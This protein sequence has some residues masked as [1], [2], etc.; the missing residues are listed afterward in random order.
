VFNELME[1]TLATP[2]DEITLSALL[3]KQSTIT[4]AFPQFYDRVKAISRKGGVRLK[5][6][7]PDGV[8]RFQAHSGTK[9]NTW[10]DVFI[11][12][13]GVE[14]VIDKAAT[15][16]DFW[17]KGKQGLNANALAND[18]IYT[19]DIQTFCECPADLYWAH[20][21]TRSRPQTN[22]KYT[23]QIDQA[24]TLRNVHQ[25]G[26]FCKHTQAVVDVLPMYHSSV[27][28]YLKKDFA[29][30]IK[31][32]EDANGPTI[33]G[34]DKP[35]DDKKLIIPGKEDKPKPKKLIVPTQLDK[36]KDEP[37][38]KPEEEPKDKPEEEPDDKEEEETPEPEP[39]KD[40]DEEDEEEE[41]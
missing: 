10:Y 4:Q 22:A 34:E 11:K 6:L 3:Q 14:G 29:K 23:L 27:A 25:K 17:K 16:P 21:Y 8:W 12:F 30:E 15:D 37:E 7:R 35:E 36:A 33:R 24:P 20:Q 18:I 32:A 40:D 9:D 26:A 1:A 41:K 31:A 38:D 28:S 39:E 2:L 13:K 19:S 5:E